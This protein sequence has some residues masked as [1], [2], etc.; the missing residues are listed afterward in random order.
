MRNMSI[1]TVITCTRVFGGWE[2]ETTIGQTHYKGFG[3][4]CLE[5]ALHNLEDAIRKGAI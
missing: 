4:S 3:M 1:G 5:E 2:A